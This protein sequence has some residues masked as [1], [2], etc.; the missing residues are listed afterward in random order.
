MRDVR[1][2]ERAY[3][4]LV[5][6]TANRIA[7]GRES[8][9]ACPKHYNIPGT[10]VQLIDVLREA[11]EDYEPWHFFLWAS[12]MQYATRW[13]HRGEPLNDLKKCQV[14]LGWLIEAVEEDGEETYTSGTPHNIRATENGGGIQR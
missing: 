7:Q 13:R 6:T 3:N 12:I 4:E 8:T 5:E 2:F 1:D 9:P 10:T 11:A 14:Y